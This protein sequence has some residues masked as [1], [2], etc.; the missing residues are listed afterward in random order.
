M[1]HIIVQHTPEVVEAFPDR[2]MMLD[3]LRKKLFTVAAA[4][5]SVPE[6][7]LTPSD[8]SIM[9]LEAGPR[10]TLMEDIQV[11]VFAHADEQRVARLDELAE[12]LCIACEEVIIY[13]TPPYGEEA[14]HVSFSVM[15]HLGQVGYFK[16]S[17]TIGLP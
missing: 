2:G 13:A 10:D 17:D 5:L 11:I 6:R 3:S 4:H 9:F 14:R 15:L 8:F 1:P 16:G 12:A 7:K